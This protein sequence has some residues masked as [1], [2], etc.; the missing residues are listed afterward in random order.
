MSNGERIGALIRRGSWRS[1]QNA[2]CGLAVTW[3]GT[4]SGAGADDALGPTPARLPVLLAPLLLRSMHPRLPLLLAPVLWGMHL[5]FYSRPYYGVC[6]LDFLYYSRP[7]YGYA[8]DLLLA[9]VLRGMHLR[10]PLLLAPVPRGMRLRLPLLAPV[11][12]SMLTNT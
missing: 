3:R 10:L 1:Q 9:P 2:R 12:R 7:Y 8:S 5:I 4:T 11:L 6:I